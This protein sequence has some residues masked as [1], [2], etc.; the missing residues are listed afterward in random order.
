MLLVDDVRLLANIVITDLTGGDLVLWVTI[1][2]GIAMTIMAQAKDDL[3]GN[4]YLTN[5]FL[6]LGIKVFKCLH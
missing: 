6:L 4:Q 5:M 1:V 2:R 3:H